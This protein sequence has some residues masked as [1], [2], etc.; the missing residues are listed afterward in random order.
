MKID[1]RHMLMVGILWLISFVL[2]MWIF[3]LQSCSPEYHFAK[4]Q[5]KGGKVQ[6]DTVTVQKV[7]TLIIDGDTVIVNRP[8]TVIEPQ[9]EY[10]TRWEVKY[11]Y[12]YLRDTVR[13]AETKIEYR[14]KETKQEEK[15]ERTKA[16]AT[17]LSL[18]I[19]FFI[20]ASILVIMLWL[21]KRK[22]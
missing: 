14:Y 6:C 1:F 3:S 17:W 13:L 22:S 9:I 8:V 19:L 2:L 15:T 16:R 4:F 5:K 21:I 18:L 20:L 11:K 7:D 12:K 10:R